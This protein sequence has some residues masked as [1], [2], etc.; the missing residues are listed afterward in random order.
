MTGPR[1][2]GEWQGW[3]VQ[4]IYVAPEPMA[5]TLDITALEPNLLAAGLR[6]QMSLGGSRALLASGFLKPIW[7]G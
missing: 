2:P 4:P 5:L 6:V 1:G 3:D 7:L